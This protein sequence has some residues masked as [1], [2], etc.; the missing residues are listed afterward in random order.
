MVMHQI[1]CCNL[2]K[3]L[4][5]FLYNFRYKSK[6]PFIKDFRLIFENCKIYNEDTSEIGEAGIKLSLLLEEGLSK[7]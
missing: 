2:D 3:I 7:L 6:K 1:N 5:D 4:N